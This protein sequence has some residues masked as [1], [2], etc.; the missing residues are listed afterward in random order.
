MSVRFVI[1]RA[2]AGKTHHCLAAVRDRLLSDPLD[3]PRLILLVP[4]QAS[5]QTERALLGAAGLRIVHR[6]E[7]LS[8]RRLALRLAERSGA[9]QPA[10]LS[11]TGRTMLL[12]HLLGK[13]A[14]ELRYFRNAERFPGFLERLGHTMD[15]LICGDVDPADLDLQTEDAE[16]DPLR[17]Y[18]L[19]DLGCIYSAYVESLGTQRL[20]PSQ[21]LAVAREHMNR[22]SWLPDAE[23]W[24]DGFAGFTRQERL[25]LRDLARYVGRLEVT[26]LMDPRK[27]RRDLRSFG[28]PLDVWAK[29]MRTRV[30]LRRALEEVGVPLDEPLLLEGSPP[31]FR[32]APQ[33]AALER[34]I[35][36]G[37]PTPAPDN[38]G[39]V[40]VFAAANRHVEIDRVVAEIV[41]LT[42][43]PEDNLR[44][45]DIGITLRDLQP[46]HDLLAAA[47]EAR[48][49]P[50]FIDRR[51]PTTHHP[52]VEWL[53]G[54]VQLAV[55][56][57]APGTAAL[58]LKTGLLS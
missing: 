37:P 48:G 52:L 51:R 42:Q 39:E 43:N 10:A 6:A 8:F 40:Q 58:L 27:A 22:C 44:L 30:E 34:S 2:G 54:L 29:P 20:D 3:G 49:I 36:Q 15:E 9:D 14:P 41:R 50:Y 23:L 18:K 4:E 55:D 28:E 45:R 7:V 46:Y 53:R 33:L 56:G 24:V 31:R 11:T 16:S 26:L 47:L 12:R 25:T 13:L 38:Q 19:G 1:G 57:F 32:T 17:R 21:Y 5:L 35:F